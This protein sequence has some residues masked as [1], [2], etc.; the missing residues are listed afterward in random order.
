MRAV[1]LAIVFALSV[2]AGAANASTISFTPQ[3]VAAV[4]VSSTFGTIAPGGT[5]GANTIAYGVDFTYGGTEGVFNDP[6]LAFG[7]TNSSGVLDLVSPVDG[8]IVLAGTTTQGVTDF[9]SAEAGLS[10]PGALTLTA[11][12]AVGNIIQSVFNGNPL[13]PNGRTTFSIAAPGIA[14]FRISGANTFGVDGITLNTPSPV[15][16]TPIPATLS[17]FAAALGGLGLVAW[18]WNKQ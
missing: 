3:S 18:R 2:S 17:L 15:Q 11:F 5:V 1:T 14:A 12:D 10:P 9:F 7:G 8:R 16:Q 13:G 6:P 4:A